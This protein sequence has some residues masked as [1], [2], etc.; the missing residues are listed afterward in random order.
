MSDFPT[1]QQ[2]APII[3][4]LGRANYE[5]HEAL[6]GMERLGLPAEEFLKPVAAARSALAPARDWAHRLD[7]ELVRRERKSTE[8]VLALYKMSTEAP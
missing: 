3:E 4:K 8:Q 5:L 7:G 2:L 6:L 1:R